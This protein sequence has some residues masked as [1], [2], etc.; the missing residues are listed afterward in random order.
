[1]APRAKGSSGSSV[2]ADYFRALY[3]TNADPWTYAAS[4]YERQKY[5]ATLDALPRKRYYAALELGCSVGVFTALL[6]RRCEAL[7][8]V[9]VSEDAVARAAQRCAGAPHVRFAVCDLLTEFPAGRFDLITFCELGFY[10]GPND[11]RR[12]RDAIA[13]A[14]FSGGDLVLVHWTPLVDGHAAT[15]DAVHE[16]FVRDAR[17]AHR[18]GARAATFRLDVFSRA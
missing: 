1:M 10:F 8:A 4:A 17:L 14:L 9:D 18:N 16:E 5:D 6:A 15:A 2:P 7:D 3:R 13:A 11:R 12:I